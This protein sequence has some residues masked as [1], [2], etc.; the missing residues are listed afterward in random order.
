[1]T[2]LFDL[3]GHDADDPDRL[4]LLGGDGCFY[5]CVVEE[6]SSGGTPQ[7]AARSDRWEFELPPDTEITEWHDA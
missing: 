4:L 2:N 1:M 7:F 3:V 5:V 6:L